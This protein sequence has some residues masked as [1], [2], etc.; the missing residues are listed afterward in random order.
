MKAGAEKFDWPV[1]LTRQTDNSQSKPAIPLRLEAPQ[2]PISF[3]CKDVVLRL[4]E[5]PA[6]LSPKSRKGVRAAKIGKIVRCQ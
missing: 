5:M 4:N 6:L 3:L 1:Q 2:L